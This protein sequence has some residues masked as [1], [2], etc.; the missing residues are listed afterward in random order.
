M[1]ELTLTILGR[2]SGKELKKI[3][4]DLNKLN[5]SQSLM[6]LLHENGVPIASSC[7]GEGV[8]KKC[9]IT[10]NCVGE[11]ISCQWK[12]MDLLKDKN[13]DKIITVNYL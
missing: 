11:I 5:Q 9:N 10:L 2:A 1:S 8:C 4:L 3:T 7:S 13:F 12:L 6:T